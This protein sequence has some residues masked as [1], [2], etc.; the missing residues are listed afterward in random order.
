[1]QH[2]GFYGAIEHNIWLKAKKIK[3]LIC[4]VD[5]VFSD[6]R[7]YLNDQESEIKAFHTRDGYGIQQLL[8]SGIN[9]AVITGR[10]SH[11]V[12]KRMNELGIIDIYQNSKNKLDAFNA[13][14]NTHQ[15]NADETAYIGDDVMD[16]PVMKQTGLSIAVADAHPLVCQHAAMITHLN[17]GFGAIREIC[18]L[19]LLSQNKI[20]IAFGLTL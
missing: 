10:K 20:D 16:L 5:G 19:I 2:Q 7:I 1:M 9:I 12:T 17:G 15:I 3:L 11:I 8:K 13:L 18:D 4:D 14:L 6:G